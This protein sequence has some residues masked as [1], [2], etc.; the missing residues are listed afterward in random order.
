MRCFVCRYIAVRASCRGAPLW[1]G[2]IPVSLRAS[3][4]LMSSSSVFPRLTFGIGLLLSGTG[5]STLLAGIVIWIEIFEAKRPNRRYLRDVLARLGPME[6][7]GIAG[8]NDD[9]AGRVGL[10]LVAVELLAETDIENA[11]HDRVDSVLGVA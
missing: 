5:L 7:P 9:A 11:G 3:V 1:G 2:S 8:Q 10:D 4:I 6:V